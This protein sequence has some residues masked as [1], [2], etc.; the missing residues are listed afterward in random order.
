MDAVY[1]REYVLDDLINR[2]SK[3]YVALMSGVVMGGGCGISVHSRHRV[4]TETTVLAMPECKIG[5]FPD[6]AGSYF[7]ARCPDQFG[8]YMGLTGLRISGGDAIRFDLADYYVPA[9]RLDE[10]IAELCRNS[11]IKDA[12]AGVSVEPPELT[13]PAPASAVRSIFGQAS[14]QKIVQ[15]L[16]AE[17]ATWAQEAFLAI[18]EAC[19]FSLE[20]TFRTIREA[21][22]KSVRDCLKTDFR[23]AQRIMRRADYFE[24]VRARIIDKDNMPLWNPARLE[25]VNANDIDVCFSPLENELTFS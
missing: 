22:S 2:Y 6:I 20:L 18:C 17:P 3:P 15:A 21:A 13:Q 11:S 24:G 10:L 25:D 7:L 8:L 4:V 5:L 19:P 1:R 14:L 16:K 12:F 23:I 9:D